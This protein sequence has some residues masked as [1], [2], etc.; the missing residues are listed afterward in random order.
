MKLE[1]LRYALRQ[2]R[3]W[4]V[5]M[6]RHAPPLSR[7]AFLLAGVPWL[8]LHR[9]AGTPGIGGRCAPLAVPTAPAERDEP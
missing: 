5:F 2:T 7:L 4:L 9:A 3:N 6:F 1:A 8:L